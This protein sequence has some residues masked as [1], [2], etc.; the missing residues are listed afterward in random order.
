MAPMH[1]KP[2]MPRHQNRGIFRQ[3]AG[4]PAME[5]RARTA[6][7]AKVAEVRAVKVQKAPRMLVVLAAGAAG[8]AA[9][10]AVAE[11]RVA[12]ALHF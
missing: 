6:R 11:K 1:R 8:A 4:P 3:Q 9:M 7:Q 5:L 12:R 10:V 2:L